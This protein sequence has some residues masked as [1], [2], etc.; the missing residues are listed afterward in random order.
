M[1]RVMIIAVL[2]A[3]SIWIFFDAKK[4]G[5]RKPFPLM[6][7]LVSLIP[8]YVAVLAYIIYRV[9]VMSK[10]SGSS[11]KSILCSKC[12]EENSSVVAVCKACG[13]NVR[14]NA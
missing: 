4:R 5:L 9:F 8:P 2:L 1:I 3:V 7:F 11:Q 6:W 14:V 10:V 12:G 13:N